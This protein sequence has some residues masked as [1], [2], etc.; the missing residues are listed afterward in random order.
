MSEDAFDAGDLKDVKEIEFTERTEV[1]IKASKA[2]E[3][4]SDRAFSIGSI[5]KGETVIGLAWIRDEETG[6]I[7]L[8]CE[9]VLEDGN[10]AR[11]F[12]PMDTFF[13]DGE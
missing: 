7:Y 11:G 2:R 9:F 5:D 13:E 8:Y 3:G 4:H 10:P 6:E 12:I 1:A